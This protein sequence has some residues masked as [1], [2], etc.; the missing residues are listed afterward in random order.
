MAVRVRVSAGPLRSVSGSARHVHGD[1]CV[2]V[3]LSVRVCDC[4][5]VCDSPRSALRPSLHVVRVSAS[6]CVVVSALVCARL[7]LSASQPVCL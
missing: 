4:L 5:C 6:V 3:R 1:M 2:G 7:C